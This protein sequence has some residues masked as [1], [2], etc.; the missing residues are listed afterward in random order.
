MEDVAVRVQRGAD[1]L[2]EHAHGWRGWVDPDTDLMD[3]TCWE[4]CVYG[5]AVAGLDENPWPDDDN[6]G[7]PDHDWAL[8]HGFDIEGIAWEAAWVELWATWHDVIWVLI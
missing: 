1:W 3:L 8:A 5:Q 7:Y 4:T 2:D 6:G